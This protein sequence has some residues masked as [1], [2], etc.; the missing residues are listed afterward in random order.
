MNP[1]Q[2]LKNRTKLPRKRFLHR[3]RIFLNYRRR[4]HE[5]SPVFILSSY[6]SGSNLFLSY[7]D[8]VPGIAFA[9]EVLNPDMAYGL[10]NRRISKKA[11]LRHIR[12][13][14]HAFPERICGAKIHMEQL[15]MHG[16]TAG[17]LRAAFPDAKFILLYRESIFEQYLSLRIAETTRQWLWNSGFRLPGKMTVDVADLQRYASRLKGFYEAALKELDAC[18]KTFLISYEQL[19]SRPEKVFNSA[20]FDFLGLPASPVSTFMKKQNTALPSDLVQNYDQIEWVAGHPAF[21]QRYSLGSRLV[22]GDPAELTM[23]KKGENMKTAALLFLFAFMIFTA[24]SYAGDSTVASPA[25]ETATAAK[26]DSDSRQMSEAPAAGEEPAKDQTATDAGVT[27]ADD[28]KKAP[29]DA[30]DGE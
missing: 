13:S 17:E 26:D 25:G 11:V 28:A 29:A 24:P 18:G 16:L 21:K 9:S 4:R 23:F 14:L 15:A 30:H 1:Y 6:R 3:L 5:K 22:E 8:S 2:A 12:H 7:F 20:L 10:R 19:A 27:P